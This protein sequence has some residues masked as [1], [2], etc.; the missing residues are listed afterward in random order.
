MCDWYTTGHISGSSFYRIRCNSRQGE[1]QSCGRVANSPEV[2]QFLGLASYY[3]RFIQNFADVAAPLHNL[4]QKDVVFS[5]SNDCSRA[6][7][8]LKCKLIGALILVYLRVRGGSR[9][10]GK[11][12]GGLINI[13]TTGGGYDRGRA[14]SRDSKG[15]WG[16]ADSSPSGVSRFFAFTFI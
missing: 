5:W 10:L 7:K 14:P 11:G 4:T 2:R 1:S 6:F 8:T 3:R 12:G 15:V 13:F 16:N 9:I